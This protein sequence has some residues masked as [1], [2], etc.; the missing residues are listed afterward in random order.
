MT[1]TELTLIVIYKS[2]WWL[3]PTIGGFI[4]YGVFEKR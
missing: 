3:I 2:L 1:N 4:G